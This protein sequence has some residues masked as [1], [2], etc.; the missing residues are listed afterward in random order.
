MTNAID[1]ILRLAEW[2]DFKPKSI[3]PG[4]GTGYPAPSPQSRAWRFPSHGS[5]EYTSLRLWITRQVSL[6]LAH[7]S[8]ARLIISD[9]VSADEGVGTSF[10]ATSQNSPISLSLYGFAYSANTAM[11]G[12]YDVELHRALQ[13][14]GLPHNTDN[15][16]EAWYTAFYAAAQVVHAG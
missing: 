6:H 16:H 4:K 10:W 8:A 11:S 2:E 12:R 3:V 7:N 5:S 1:K 14:C 15:G 9:A 13:S